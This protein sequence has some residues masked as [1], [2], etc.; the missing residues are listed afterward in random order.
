MY[1][2]YAFGLQIHSEKHLP[3]LDRCAHHQTE[4]DVCF[5]W[6][7]L[8]NHL[9][10]PIPDIPH[11]FAFTNKKELILHI[12]DVAYFLVKD[13]HYVVIE[14]YDHSSIEDIQTFLLGSAIGAILN[15]HEFYAL[16]ACSLEVEGEVVAICGD[17]GIGKSSIAAKYQ[18]MGGRILSDDVSSIKLKNGIPYVHPGYSSIKLWKDSVKTLGESYQILDRVQRKFDK[19]IMPLNVFA[20][21]AIPLKQV[22]HLQVGDVQEVQ[23]LEL[24]NVEKMSFLKRN[25]YRYCFI[26]GMNLKKWHFLFIC[27]LAQNIKNTLV[28]RPKEMQMQ[29]FHEYLFDEVRNVKRLVC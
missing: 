28:I 19:F 21:K 13:K 5:I 25:S 15:L 18:Q 4:K 20:S 26:K 11:W 22:I 12:T 7:S 24:N 8:S 27:S 29:E 23:H 16:H 1:S 6:D 10:E 3:R 2:Y 17:S 9:D 14:P